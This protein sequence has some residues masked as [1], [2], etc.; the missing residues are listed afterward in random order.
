MIARSL[1]MLVAAPALVLAACGGGYDGASNGGPP[2]PTSSLATGVTTAGAGGSAVLANETF[3]SDRTLPPNALSADRLEDAG[4]ATT[5]GGGDVRMAHASSP[6]VADWEL[7]SPAPDG[8]L[9]W[10]PKVVLDVLADAGMGA[11]IVSVEAVDWPDACLGMAG[12]DEACA[13]VITPGYL[14]VL[15][16]SGE[17]IEYHASRAGR[18][19]KVA[20][21]AG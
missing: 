20:A 12:P 13:E 2:V 8:W 5:A 6:D 18:Y 7:V 15:D 14:V 21:D 17:A 10:R 4:T 1:V 16:R 3:I 11:R 19:R 9:V